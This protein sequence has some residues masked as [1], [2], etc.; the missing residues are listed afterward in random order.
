MNNKEILKKKLK[1]KWGNFQ[2]I[3]FPPSLDELDIKVDMIK[4]D[5]HIAGLV[6]SYLGGS[7]IDKNSLS[8]DKNIDTKLNNF[9][10]RTQNDRYNYPKYLEYK[11]HIDELTILLTKCL[12]AEKK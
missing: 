5:S 6:T 8:L 4:L 11:K 2:K 12:E 10:P 9:I 7:E 1:E 3:K